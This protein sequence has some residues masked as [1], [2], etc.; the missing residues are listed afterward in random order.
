VQRAPGNPA[1]EWVWRREEEVKGQE[2]RV[3]VGGGFVFPPPGIEREEVE[4]TVFVA[5]GVGV[6]PFLSMIGWIRGERGKEWGV[7]TR[8]LWSAKAGEWAYLDR[9][10][11]DC[12]KEHVT[13]FETG[14]E[15]GEKLDGWDVER[16][17]IGVEDLKQAAQGEKTLVYVCGPRGFADFCVEALVREVSV[18]RKR[19]FCEKWW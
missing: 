13:L 15:T 10:E 14:A 8:L 1:A 16:R 18:D 4:R 12:G 9:I 7:E 5:G 2:V 17:R 19:V 3:R 11:R 6:N